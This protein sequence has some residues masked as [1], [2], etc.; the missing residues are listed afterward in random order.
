MAGVGAF[1][2]LQSVEVHNGARGT[3]AWTDQA[4]V[5]VRLDDMGGGKGG[6][7]VVARWVYDAGGSLRM[8]RLECKRERPGSL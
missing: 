4:R 6:G 2:T 5:W 8:S 1:V 3:V 7:K